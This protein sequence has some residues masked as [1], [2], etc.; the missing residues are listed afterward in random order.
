MNPVL[1]ILVLIGLIAL[2]FLLRPL[3]GKIGKSVMKGWT[4]SSNDEINKKEEANS[5]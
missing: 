5:E 2:W 4:D 3:F 1:I